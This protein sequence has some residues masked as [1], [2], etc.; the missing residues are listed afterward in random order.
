MIQKLITKIFGTKHERDV[1]KLWPIVEQINEYF[2]QFEKLSDEE[3]Q[4]KTEEFKERLAAGETTDD[5]LPEAFAAVKQACKRLLGKKWM[6]VGREMTWNMVPFDVQLLGGIVLHQGKIA[7]M[8]TG[9]GKTLVATMPLYLN[10]LEGKG[11]HLVTVNDYLAQ[12]DAE[13]MGEVYKFLGLTVGVILNNMDAR[14]RREAYNCDITYGTNNEFGFDYLRDNM[15]SSP[16][17]I[18]QIRGHH[19]AIVDEVDSVLIDEARTPLIISGPVSGDSTAQRYRE[20]KPYVERLVANQNRL[21]NRMVMEAEELLKEGKDREAAVKLFIA[22][23]GAPKHKR[24]LKLYHEKGIKTLVQQVENDYY[25]DKGQ[26]KVS[27]ETYFGEL[28]YVIDEKNHIIDLTEKGREALNP[29]D[30]DMFLLPDLGEEIAKIEND[31]SLSVEE[32]VIRKEE[33]H[34]LYTERSEKLQNIS[35]LLRAYTL[36]EKDQEYVVQ[37][38]KV[39]IVDEFTGRILHGRRYSDGLHQAIEAKEN[40]QIEKETQTLATITLQNY[41]RMYDKLAGMTGT[42]ETEAAE[43]WEIYKLDVVV[44]PTNKPVIRIDYDDVVYRSKRE[45]YNAVIE[46]IIEERE[47][48]RPVLVGTTTVEVSEVLSRMLKRRGI[49]HNVLNAKQHAREAEIIAHAGEPQAVTIATNMAGRGTDIKLGEGVREVGGLAIIGTERHESRRIDRQLRGRAGRQGDPG[50]SIFFLSLE[51]DLM[52]LFGSERVA[53]I[54][55]RMGIEEGE[56]I[57]HPMISRSIEKAQKKVEMQNFSI[58]KRLLEYD[59][60]MN[61]Q[62]EIIYDRRK[63]ALFQEDTREEVESILDEFIDHKLAMYAPP[64]AHPEEW[65]LDALEEEIGKV[66]NVSLYQVRQNLD[67]YDHETLRQYIR[68]QA[69]HVYE[70]KE[71]RIGRERMSVLERYFILRVIDE[72]WKD[73]LY[74]M[75][76]LKEGIHLRAYGQKDPLLEY[77]REAFLMFEKLIHDIN[78]ETLQWLWKFQLVEEPVNRAEARKRQPQRM[79]LI[80]ESADGLGFS[81]A[82]GEETDIQKAGKQ[83]SDKKQ[84]IRVGEKIG[85]NDPC[86]CGSG[87]KYKKCHGAVKN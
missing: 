87:K 47:K 7:E 84:P 58:R 12:R 17:E 31:S 65:D 59:D 34:N 57:T 53:R 38:G 61:Q 76:V 36:Y 37:D 77:K 83:R 9:E 10:A 81:S 33:L 75:D 86:P 52:R 5:I 24:L 32:K 22:E 39:Q 18:V 45:K 63:V 67:E 28:Y 48:G 62:R 29:N 82:V 35:Q 66:L 85:P 11:A 80:H 55:D 78:E 25:R 20:M 79:Q 8:A 15:A 6:V 72:K 54:M 50:S 26:N 68:D 51:D 14:Q 1:K 16:D 56:V 3:L 30:P 49:P 74:D 70:L 19:Y 69:L 40:V 41:F 4:K 73:H 42:A 27:D 46:K 13:W 64:K 71:K 60:V 2:E 43:F 44:I 23:R 21:V